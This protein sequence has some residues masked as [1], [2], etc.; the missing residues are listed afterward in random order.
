MTNAAFDRGLASLRT[1]SRWARGLLIAGLVLSV[2]GFGTGAALLIVELGG[3]SASYWQSI[4]V[5]ALISGILTLLNISLFLAT[6]ILILMWIHRAHGNLRTI[7]LEGLKYS[8]AWAVGSFFVP[9]VNLVVPFR[10]MR[11]LWNRSFGEPDYFSASSVPNANSWWACFVSSNLISM[12]LVSISSVG[13]VTGVHVVTP[14]GVNL[15]LALFANVLGMGAIV[16]LHRIIGAITK[17]Q[18]SSAGI[19]ETFA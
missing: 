14:P 17:A 1:R 6:A 15:A 3:D 10:A 11:E 13:M 5:V 7:G 8:P 16:F 2:L 9:L 4:P 18:G 12:F 19:S